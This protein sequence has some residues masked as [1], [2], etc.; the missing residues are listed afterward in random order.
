M[1]DTL[2][3][4]FSA[5][6]KDPL[7]GLAYRKAQRS[8]ATPAV[9]RLLLLHG[10]GSNEVNLADLAATVSP[11]VQVYL[12][13]GPIVLG[14]DQFGWFQVSFAAGSPQINPVQAEDSRQRLLALIESLAVDGQGERLPTF[15]AGFS[16]GGIMS[17]SV[18]LTSSQ[19]VAGFGLLSGRILPEIESQLAPRT[20]LASISAFVAH[21]RLD[22]KLPVDWAEKADQWLT[23]LGVQHQ[24]RL[25]PIGH[26]LTAEVAADFN[27]WLEATLH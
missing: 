26:E 14:T 21:G 16:Q 2:A 4:A 20:A 18:G 1:N 22:N 5:L 17:A 3:G 11:T 23:A 6:K 25:Y 7:S 10:V 12:V 9:A 8:T 24:T 27:R 19:A 13:R 15:I